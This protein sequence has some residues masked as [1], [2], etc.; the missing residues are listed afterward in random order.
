[1]IKIIFILVNMGDGGAERTAINLLNHL[2]QYGIDAK[3]GLIKK[4][5]DAYS[6]PNRQIIDI[7]ESHNE[8][9]F[10]FLSKLRVKKLDFLYYI[11]RIK[12]IISFER[13]DVIM[14]FNYGPHFATY[15]ALKLIKGEKPI[16][17]VREGTNAAFE[18]KNNWKY[19]L[20]PK[21]FNSADGIIAISNGIK[22]GLMHNFNIISEKIEVIYNPVDLV[23]IKEKSKNYLKNLPQKPYLLAVG[24]LVYEKGFDILINAF[25]DI[26]MNYNINLVILGEGPLKSVLKNQVLSL[27]LGDRVL[28]MGFQKNPYPFFS[29]AEAF[30]LSSR[31]EG[32]AHVIVEALACRTPVISSDCKYGPNEILQNGKYG[33]LYPPEDITALREA[34]K[35]IHKEK[36]IRINFSETGYKRAKDFD[37]VTI[38]RQYA[39]YI[40][41][42]YYK[43]KEAK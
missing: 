3:I 11:Y 13:P 21:V 17:I 20:L 4:E 33:I 26:A 24:R 32:F 43:K 14:S 31:S 27:N 41:N 7:P 12:S 18:L 25:R 19:R 5:G 40:K 29:S 37:A 8:K 15:F 10:K 35:Y 23:D 38:S 22:D 42:V 36:N 2:Q 30:I 28:F 34:I 9:L 1:M 39:E 16:W 6:V